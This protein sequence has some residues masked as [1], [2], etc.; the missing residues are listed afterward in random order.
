MSEIIP[1]ALPTTDVEGAPLEA[2]PLE[3]LSSE[4]Q[5][6]QFVPEAKESPAPPE[7]AGIWDQVVDQLQSQLQQLQTQVSRV[8]HLAGQL[9]KHEEDR[10]QDRRTRE[11]LFEKLD[12]SRPQFQFQLLR[13]LVQRLA[14]MFDLVSDWARQPPTDVAG[15]TTCMNVLHRQFLDVL[16]LHGIT[17]IAP[18]VDAPFDRRFHHVV[19]TQP[20]GEPSRHE[21][22]ATLL[23][24]GYLYFGQN[25][26]NGTLT[27]SVIRPARVVTWKYDPAFLPREQPSTAEETTPGEAQG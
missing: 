12:A 27:P 20:T 21:Q 4:S 6:D 15:F 10:E 17:A 24:N 18:Q 1:T 9:T 23:Q 14:T 13:P 2:I 11:A 22:V 3:V 16:E 19:Q 8:E 7:A 25:T 5:V 26:Q